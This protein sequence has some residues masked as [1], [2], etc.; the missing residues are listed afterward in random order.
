[1]PCLQ[2]IGTAGATALLRQLQVGSSGAELKAAALR[3]LVALVTLQPDCGQVLVAARA[4]PLLTHIL[5]SYLE[6]SEAQGQGAPSPGH[7]EGEWSSLGHGSVLV[8]LGPAASSPGKAV[9]KRPGQQQLQQQRQQAEKAGT[10]AAAAAVAPVG[11][12]A[13]E[14]E[15]CHNAVLLLKRLAPDYVVRAVLLKHSCTCTSLGSHMHMGNLRTTT[16]LSG[17]VVLLVRMLY[18]CAP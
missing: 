2:V 1:M 18:S 11:G 5:N 6:S 15:V 3:A 13:G 16:Q 17:T 14:C 8:R 4:V 9:H 7:A 10:G 12:S